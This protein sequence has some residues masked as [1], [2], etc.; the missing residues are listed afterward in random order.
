MT[1]KCFYFTFH[2]SVPESGFAVDD[3]SVVETPGVYFPITDVIRW[4]REEF[5]NTVQINITNVIEISNRDFKQ[6][7]SDIENES[8]E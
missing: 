6:L 4:A 5:G 7:V 2:I 3:F 8:A 1:T